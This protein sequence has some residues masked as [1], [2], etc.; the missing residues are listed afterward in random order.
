MADI[1]ITDVTTSAIDGTGALDHILRTVVEHVSEEYSAGRVEGSDY[2]TVYL[3]SLQTA[4]SESIQFILNRQASDKQAELLEEQRLNVAADT[5]LK[6]Q[7]LIN[8][9]LEALNIPKQGAL[10]DS[11]KANTDADT[12]NK[13]QQLVNLTLEAANI[14]KQGALLDAQVDKAAKE[15]QLITQQITNLAAELLNIPKE[16][17]VLDGQVSK[18]GA[19]GQLLAQKHITEIAQV[20]DSWEGTPVGG[21]IKVQ[22]DLQTQQK[23]TFI[24]ESEQRAL[25]MFVDTFN[26]RYSANPDTPQ[27]GTGLEDRNIEAIAKKVLEGV[28][29][30]IPVDEDE[31]TVG[32]GDA[33][34]EG[35]ET[36]VEGEEVTEP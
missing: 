24:R 22:K 21:V 2:A 4:L 9:E 34:G 5:A 23:E 25:K 8:L 17:A 16:G 12:D 13:E 28:G 7:Q 6:R 19:E 35:E 15:N 11:Q 10:L 31:E 3:G 36:V 27:T 14:P 30:V 18:L 1:P 29:V 33:T 32:D 26:V 20:A